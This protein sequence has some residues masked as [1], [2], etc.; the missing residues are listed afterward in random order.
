ME[1]CTEEVRRAVVPMVPVMPSIAIV[2]VIAVV[3]GVMPVMTV[4]VAMTVPVSVSPMFT[5]SS[6]VHPLSFSMAVST[7]TMLVMHSGFLFSFSVV[8]KLRHHTR[9]IVL[10]GLDLFPCREEL[11]VD[12]GLLVLDFAKLLIDGI[13]QLLHFLQTDECLLLPFLV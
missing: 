2:V 1:A 3:V 9:G 13:L 12:F 4:P 7:M 10:C 8:R 11:C 5:I 6:H